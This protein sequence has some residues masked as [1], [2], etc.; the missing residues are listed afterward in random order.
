MDD[1]RFIRDGRTL[2]EWLPDLID[3]TP[4]TRR[5]AENAVSAM[6]W[7]API[8]DAT[9]YLHL[10]PDPEA[11]RAEW[12]RQIQAVLNDPAF[13]GVAFV[14]TALQRMHE[15]RELSNERWANE[16]ALLDAQFDKPLS[17]PDEQR[18]QARLKHLIALE[19]DGKTANSFGP[20][21]LKMAL[22]HI[23]PL[24]LRMQETVR[25]AMRDKV[26]SDAMA[27]AVKN[28]GPVGLPFAADLMADEVIERPD[29]LA[30]IAC[31][32]HNIVTALLDRVA[33]RNERVAGH[34]AATLQE[35]G[36][37][38]RRVLPSLPDDLWGMLDGS[39]H[40][41]MISPVL[42]TL[43]PDRRDVFERVVEQARPS[44]PDIRAHEGYPQ[45][46]YDA[47]MYRRGPALE[48]LGNF[49]AFAPEA[50]AVLIDALDT[51][52]EYD[53]DWGYE[54]GEHGRV[55]NS[56]SQLGDAAAA[57]VPALIPRIRFDKGEIDWRIVRFFGQLGPL[58]AAALPALQ[59]LAGETDDEAL[60][61]PEDTGKPDERTDPLRWAIWRI[62]SP[63]PHR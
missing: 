29:V 48:M 8:V 32:D 2:R 62:V 14:E 35:M 53:P 11:H 42:A 38:A 43:S 27:K 36:E 10:P 34:A 52:T 3:P 58:A 21:V 26:T 59:E 4:L 22:E 46:T 51:F 31:D 28:L 16:N 6:W 17:K 61:P 23:G 5:R 40:D 33:S 24:L 20:H 25:A 13:P 49:R 44:P 47:T 7:G 45:Y 60:V 56:L 39:E 50:V 55:V 1:D 9:T 37:R 15:D 54:N 19:N 30:A 18:M 41:N 63:A 57:A 12:G